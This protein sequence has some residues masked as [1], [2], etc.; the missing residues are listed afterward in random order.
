MSN[1]ERFFSH[2]QKSDAFLFVFFFGF[3]SRRLRMLAFKNDYSKGWNIKIYIYMWYKISWMFLMFLTLAWNF[4]HLGYWMADSNENKREKLYVNF[5]AF[6]F[7]F[8]KMFVIFVAAGSILC[9]HVEKHVANYITR[10][11]MKKKPY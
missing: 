3:H 10:W 4:T 9:K 6:F 2:F 5:F 8:Y 1:F 11:P 7:F